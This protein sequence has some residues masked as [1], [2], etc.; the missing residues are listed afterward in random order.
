MIVVRENK[1]KLTIII[2]KLLWGCPL[3]RKLKGAVSWAA[4]VHLYTLKIIA[5]PSMT[6]TT[7]TILQISTKTFEGFDLKVKYEQLMTLS[8]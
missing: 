1:K 7:C 6:T 5:F 2:F 8:L 3:V 4:Y